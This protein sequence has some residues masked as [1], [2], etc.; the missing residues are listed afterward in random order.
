MLAKWVVSQV[1]R[2]WRAA[3][4]ARR[5]ERRLAAELSAYTDRELTELGVARGDIAALVR[6]KR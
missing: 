6:A 3:A 4:H 2:E 5:D 1:W